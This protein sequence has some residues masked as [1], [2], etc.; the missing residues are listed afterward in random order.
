MIIAAMAISA[1]M[2]VVISRVMLPVSPDFSQAQDQAQDI[3]TAVG[4]A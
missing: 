3:A 2:Q 1:A 4:F